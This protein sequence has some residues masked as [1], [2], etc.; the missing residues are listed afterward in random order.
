M[1]GALIGVSSADLLLGLLMNGLMGPI[2]KTLAIAVWQTLP[3][4][5]FTGLQF[6]SALP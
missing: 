3:A 2:M 6:K 5:C 1:I 4:F